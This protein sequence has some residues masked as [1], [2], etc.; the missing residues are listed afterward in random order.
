MSECPNGCDREYPRGCSK[1]RGCSCECHDP[2][3][4]L[5]AVCKEALPEIEK[6]LQGMP[7]LAER[8][9]DAI[10]RVEL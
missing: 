2:A 6:C 9:R 7:E 8:M 10:R 4:E 5:L 1:L 3:R